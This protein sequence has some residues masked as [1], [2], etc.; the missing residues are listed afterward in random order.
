MYQST[1]EGFVT[2]NEIAPDDFY[3]SAYYED[4]FRQSKLI[5]ETG[6]CVL[7]SDDN[8]YLVVAGQN[9]IVGEI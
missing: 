7:G 8:V 2:L 6:F 5:D 9:Q 1:K 3:H 4:Y